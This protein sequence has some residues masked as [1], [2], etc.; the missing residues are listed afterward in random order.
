MPYIEIPNINS[1]QRLHVKYRILK[2]RLNNANYVRLL[3]QSVLDSYA[4]IDWHPLKCILL[5]NITYDPQKQQEQDILGCGDIDTL[6]QTT[7]KV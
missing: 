2:Y 7:S 1:L 3:S 5:N 6:I 4:A